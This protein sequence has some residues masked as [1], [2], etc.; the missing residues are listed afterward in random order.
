[1][2]KQFALHTQYELQSGP[3]RGLAFGA[4]ALSV[5]DRIVLA[6]DHN[7]IVEGY[8]RL[9]LHLS[10]DAMDRLRLSLLLRNVTDERYVE[11]PN[12]AYSYGHFFGAPRSVLLRADY[13][14]QP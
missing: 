12:S 3:L 6:G 14:F 10:Y 9:D 8:E 5:G 7:L 13:G 1:V 2:K 11:R 4:T